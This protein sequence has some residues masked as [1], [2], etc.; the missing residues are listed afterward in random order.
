[1]A[2]I[3]LLNMNMLYIKFPDGRIKRDCHLALGP[4][5][6]ISALKDNGIEV[7]FRDYQILDKEE[8]FTPEVFVDF[9]KN[10]SKIVGISSMANL[11]PFILYALPYFKEKYPDTI[12]IL[13]GVGTASIEEEILK[14]FKEVDIIHKGEGELSAPILIKALR[15]IKS[16]EDVPNIYYRKGN[17]IVFNKKLPRITNLDN[18]AYPYYNDL[19]FNIY[20]GHNILGSRGCPYPCTFCSIT[21]IWEHKAYS[22]S[23][24]SIIDEM[25]FMS[26]NFGVKQF[27]F[28]DEYFVS[29]PK[30]I[31]DFSKKLQKE[32]LDITYKVFARVD[33]V[34]KSS[35]KALADSGCVE[36]RFGIESGSDRIL[37]LTK[38]GF[39]SDLAFKVLKLA[40]KYI[41]SVDAFYVWGYPFE[42]MDDFQKSIFQM[43]SLRGMGIRILPSLLTFLPQTE[44]YQKLEDKNKLEFSPYL[45]PEYMVMGLEN[46]VSVRIKI[47]EKYTDFINFIKA[48]KDIFPGFFSYDI[49]GNIIPKLGILEEFDFYNK[50][51]DES[52]GAHSPE[53]HKDECNLTLQISD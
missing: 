25:K 18:I 34:N 10:P 12:I 53:I 50:E 47:H 31:I 22:R 46:R 17:Q 30:R 8:L 36:I 1:M 28:Q 52:C 24:K 6:L 13:G 9:L 44:I 49:N 35:I 14:R 11:I 51:I 5:Y 26:Q 16:L 19:D 45:L 33:L 43:I 41:R 29:S 37:K 27:L 20:R 38:K 2:D 21:P 39:K 32:K 48:N 42:T 7:D 23:N 3:T 15:D 4:L 40:K